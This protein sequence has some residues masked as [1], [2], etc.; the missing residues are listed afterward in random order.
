M[1]VA[2]HLTLKHHLADTLDQVLAHDS[3]K[4]VL[5]KIATEGHRGKADVDDRVLAYF[6]P[7]VMK[8]SVVVRIEDI[9]D[10]QSKSRIHETRDDGATATQK[11]IAPFRSVDLEQSPHC[12][13]GRGCNI[14]FFPHSE[15]FCAAI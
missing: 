3:K 8:V 11:S 2:G 14:S 1:L 4:E 6:L 15:V 13:R 10:D 12:G 5:G 9:T 7:H